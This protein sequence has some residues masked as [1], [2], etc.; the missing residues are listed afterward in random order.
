MG[1]PGVSDNK[2]SACSA[3]DLS[4]I[5][6]LGRSPGE[7]SGFPLHYS[8]LEN[9]MDRGAWRATVHGVSESEATK[10]EI[11]AHPEIKTCL[12]EMS[13]NK[14]LWGLFF[15]MPFLRQLFSLSWNQFNNTS[16]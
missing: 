11:R 15:L 4:S 9:P 10:Q 12:F 2:E 3:G 16:S 5:P 8:G 14:A 13:S 7:R 6:G 1:F